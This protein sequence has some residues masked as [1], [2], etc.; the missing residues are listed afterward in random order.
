MP[1]PNGFT[2]IKD[3]KGNGDI[4]NLLGVV[5]SHKE[6]KPS[7][8]TDWTLEF[9]L[10]DDFTSGLVGNQS[11]IR[12]RMFR[13]GRDK[14]PKISG[15][16][17][18]VLLRR[19]KLNAWNQRVDCVSDSKSWSGVLVFPSNKIPIPELSQAYQL[20]NQR[21]PYDAARGTDDATTQEQ[22]A[23]IHLKHAASGSVQQVQ[24]H[25]ATTSFKATT[26]DKLSLIKNLDFSRFYDVRALVLNSYY[27]NGGE[28][29]LKVTDYTTNTNLFWYIDPAEATDY[30]VANKQWTG[31]YGQLTLSVMLWGN[32]A[33]WA[34]ENVSVGDYVFLRNMRTKMSRANHLEGALHEDREDRN[35]V[36][37]RKLTNQSDIAEIDQ[38]RQAY[39]KTRASKSALQILQSAPREPA[40]QKGSKK[41]EKKKRARELKEAEQKEL[42]KMAEQWQAA[43]SGI[44]ANGKSSKPCNSTKLRHTV[45]A[46]FPEMKL[47]TIS[48]IVYAPHLKTRSTEGRN[49]FKLPFVNARHRSRVRVVDVWPP[50]IEFFA[51]STRDPD[52]TGAPNDGKKELWEW[53]FVLLLEDANIPPNTVSEKLRVVVDNSVGQRLLNQNALE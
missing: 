33:A 16:G 25:V 44:N 11:S 32:N 40:A 20:G 24:Q 50:E 14:L 35:K 13:S 37:I 52:W 39:E 27:H 4:V 48:D 8:G 26:R 34:R 29:E 9:E 21:L 42:A 7:R 43:R 5:V 1:L 18:I 45:R 28:M 36:D 46:G 49:E 47:S 17:D 51:H 41:A 10:Q 31:P 30:M 53:G 3:A 22:M 12:C 15:I 23:V 38:R 2:A 6:P 19:F